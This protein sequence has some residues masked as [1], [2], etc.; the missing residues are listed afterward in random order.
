MAKK[1]HQQD[2]LE[3]SSI[4][5]P[6]GARDD[7]LA[8]A[9]VAATPDAEEGAKK[10][11]N[12]TS[13][14]AWQRGHE[15]NLELVQLLSEYQSD[16]LVANWCQDAQTPLKESCVQLMEA[17]RKFQAW[18]KVRRY[19]CALFFINKAYYQLFLGQELGLWE[20]SNFLGALQDYYHLTCATMLRFVDRAEKGPKAKTGFKAPI[21]K[22]TKTE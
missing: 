1:D 18:E 5:S 10:R 20:V 6:E 14:K 7:A 11:K 13:L 19:E 22:N 21:D 3:E 12:F 17:Y 4:S 8:D 2:T 9:P 16:P 15:L